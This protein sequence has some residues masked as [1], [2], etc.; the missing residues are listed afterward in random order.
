MLFAQQGQLQKAMEYLDK[1]IDLRPDYPEALNNLGVLYVRIKNYPQ[2]EAQFKTCIRLA[3]GFD[4]S[5]LNLANLYAMRDN[6]SLARDVLEELLR[7]QPGNPAANQ[8][9]QALQSPR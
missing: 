8:A 4:R 7:V 6:S 5:Y 1:A 3:P 2:A 9:L